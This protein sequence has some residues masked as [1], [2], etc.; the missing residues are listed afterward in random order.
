MPPPVNLGLNLDKGCNTAGSCYVLRW[1][2]IYESYQSGFRPHYRIET[3]LI[4]MVNDLQ[5]LLAFVA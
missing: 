2:N 4:K 3:A 5:R 1:N